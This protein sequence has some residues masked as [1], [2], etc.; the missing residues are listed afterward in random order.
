MENKVPLESLE[1][2]EKE[3]AQVSVDLKVLLV[4]VV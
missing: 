2:V 4:F 1:H 3:E